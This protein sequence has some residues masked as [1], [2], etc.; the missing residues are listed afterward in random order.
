LVKIEISKESKFG[1]KIEF[2]DQN[3]T[4]YMKISLEIEIWNNL[5]KIE[6]CNKNRHFCSKSKSKFGEI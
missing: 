6:I 5:V 4:V 2:V 1:A 3:Q